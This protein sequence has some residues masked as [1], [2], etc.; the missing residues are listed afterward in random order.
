MPVRQVEVVAPSRLHFGMFSFGQ[1][2]LRAYGGVGMMIDSPGLRIVVRIDESAKGAELTTGDKMTTDNSVALDHVRRVAEHLGI[3]S[4]VQVEMPCGPRAHAGLG[5]GTQLGMSI[6]AALFALTG[7]EVSSAAELAAACG[8][9]KRSAVGAHGFIHGGWI[10]E[11]GKRKPE[12]LSPLVARV[13]FPADWRMAL[14]I[15]AKVEGLHGVA[16]R[17]A[18]ERLPP[19]DRS[20]TDQLC[21]V[22]L[23]ELTPAVKVADFAGFCEGLKVFNQLAGAC[24]AAE[25]GGVYAPSSQATI[26]RL[27]RAGVEHFAQTSWGPTVCVPFANQADAEQF[28]KRWRAETSD[29]VIIAAGCN[30]GARVTASS[31]DAP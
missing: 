18:F 13:D 2:N 7:R 10:V 26:D 16:E 23:L 31:N 9:G 6:A 4:H 29:E 22:A 21:R 3:D 30:H 5:S 25:Q 27:L 1:T 17:R 14:V 11:A 19:V 8:R 15:P 28:A 24:F 20:L 12:E